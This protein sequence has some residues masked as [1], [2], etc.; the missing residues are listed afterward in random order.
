MYA[1]LRVSKINKRSEHKFSEFIC[2]IFDQTV[3]QNHRYWV[4]MLR[5]QP[6]LL[7]K[8]RILLLSE[9]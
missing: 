3:N 9:G 1:C 8:A 6:L 4:E 5:I 2:L 7:Y